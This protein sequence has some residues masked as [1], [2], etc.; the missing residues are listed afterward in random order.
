MAIYPLVKRILKNV[1][2]Y[3]KLGIRKSCKI[4]ELN[5][6]VLIVV[7]VCSTSS[8]EVTIGVVHVIQPTVLDF[9][10]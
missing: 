8:P 9:L 2:A 1:M 4:I 5:I 10:K 3:V 7:S 6:P